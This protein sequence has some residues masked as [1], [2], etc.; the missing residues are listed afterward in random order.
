MHV[1]IYETKS[2]ESNI[3]KLRFDKHEANK[4]CGQTN[5]LH[6]TST[7]WTFWSYVYAAMHV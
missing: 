2:F 4:P 3:T 6:G 7:L 5:L 1:V